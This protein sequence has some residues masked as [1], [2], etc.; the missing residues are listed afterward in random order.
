MQVTYEVDVPYVEKLQ[1][2]GLQY[3]HL[4]CHEELFSYPSFLVMIVLGMGRALG[5]EVNT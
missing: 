4:E 5:Y 2:K 1:K 3:V